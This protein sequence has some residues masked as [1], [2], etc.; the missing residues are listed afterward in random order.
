MLQSA[1]GLVF[2]IMKI[3]LKSQSMIGCIVYM[4]ALRIFMVSCLYLKVR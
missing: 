2:P 1:L 4:I 3:S